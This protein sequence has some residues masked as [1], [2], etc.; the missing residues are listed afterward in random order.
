M[1]RNYGSH[2]LIKIR[3]EFEDIEQVKTETEPT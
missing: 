3:H 2:F 1:L